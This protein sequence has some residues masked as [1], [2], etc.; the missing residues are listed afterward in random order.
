MIVRIASR[1]TRRIADRTRADE[2]RGERPVLL[3]DQLLAHLK[4]MTMTVY[5]DG[6]P[7]LFFSDDGVDDDGLFHGHHVNVTLRTNGEV[8]DVSLQA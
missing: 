4:L 7:S 3:V 5:H 2:W 1:R 6:R 8:S